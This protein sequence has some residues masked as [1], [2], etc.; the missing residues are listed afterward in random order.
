MKLAL[1]TAAL[2][3]KGVSPDAIEKVKEKI[4]VWLVSAPRYDLSNR[5][6]NLN[7]SIQSYDKLNDLER[8]V[9]VA[10]RLP[11]ISDVI[12]D[13]KDE[14]YIESVALDKLIDKLL[15]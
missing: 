6:W 15:K 5:L 4:G 12:F 9:D 13:N 2:I 14:E 1:N 8:I 10:N 11:V 7:S 3:D